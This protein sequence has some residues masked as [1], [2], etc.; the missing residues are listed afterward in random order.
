MLYPLPPIN[1]ELSED[2][3]HMHSCTWLN[4]AGMHNP[5]PAGPDPAREHV[6]S[7]PRRILKSTRNFSWMTAIL[8][9][10]L[11]FLE[12]LTVLQLI[13]KHL[14]HILL[15]GNNIKTESN[16]RGLLTIL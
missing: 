2:V 14:W 10:N 12:P 9:K 5:R 11:N 4:K 8:W 13:T 3:Q 16:K 1:D 6:L 7:G 15:G